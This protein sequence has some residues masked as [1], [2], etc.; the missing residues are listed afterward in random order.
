M[1]ISRAL[2]RVEFFFTASDV[3]FSPRKLPGVRVVEHTPAGWC[4]RC[5]APRIFPR[6]SSFFRIFFPLAYK[7]F[8]PFYFGGNF[9]AEN[10]RLRACSFYRG[11]WFRHVSLLHCWN[12]F[13]KICVIAE[14][15]FFI[16]QIII[17]VFLMLEFSSLVLSILLGF[18]SIV[19]I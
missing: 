16:Y 7:I 4:F 19:G 12:C 8:I 2:Y 3:W 1:L 5:C 15:P 18:S 10:S 9:S 14:I 11:I 13:V 6:R 17:L